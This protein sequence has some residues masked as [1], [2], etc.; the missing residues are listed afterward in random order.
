MLIV[1]H[2]VETKASA[3][4]IW[5]IWQ[6]VGNWNTWDHGLEFSTSNGPFVVGTMGTVKPKGGPLVH[7]KLTCVE[8]PHQGFA[9]FIDEAKLPFTRIIVTHF[10]TESKEKT[11]VTHQI[12]MHGPL[13]FFFAFVIGRDMKKNLPR[14]MEA[15]IKKAETLAG[16]R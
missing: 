15:M 3:R 4:A 14:E 8:P 12:E 16:V 6:D 1:K 5:D 2:T 11:Q 10:L 9:K 7:T 13:A